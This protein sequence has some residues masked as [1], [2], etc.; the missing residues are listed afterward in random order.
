MLE[1]I[2]D[3]ENFQIYIDKVDWVGL[4]NV[5][6]MFFVGLILG[7]VI[8]DNYYDAQINKCAQQH[9][10]YECEIKYVPKEKEG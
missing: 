9:N 8:T 5:A 2:D 3:M 4:S 10:V 1:G 7:W 6:V